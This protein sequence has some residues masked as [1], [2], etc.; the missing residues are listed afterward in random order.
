MDIGDFDIQQDAGEDPV[1]TDGLDNL[2]N[3]L[4]QEDDGLPQEDDGKYAESEQEPDS[5]GDALGFPNVRSEEMGNDPLGFPNVQSEDE[6]EYD[7]NAAIKEWEEKHRETL[8]QK[9][10]AARAEK[11]KLLEKA[12]EDIEAFYEERKKKKATIK[13]QNKEAEENYFSEM[14]DLMEFGAAW[15]KVGRLV[16]LT[17]KSNEKPGTSKVDRMRTLLIQLK[18]EKP[19]QE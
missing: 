2:D 19:R 5:G 15:E 13:I 7:D 4:P 6:K 11:E 12:K 16:N 9:R 17:P 3:F 14:K 10:N 1:A 8:L 18:N